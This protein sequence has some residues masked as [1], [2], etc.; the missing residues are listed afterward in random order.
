V[1][2]FAR[3]SAA[4]T[5]LYGLNRRAEQ[6]LEFRPRLRK[7]RYTYEVSVLVDTLQSLTQ[8]DWYKF[9]ARPRLPGP[10]A[11]ALDSIADR[12]IF[13]TGAGGSIGSQLSLRIAR[14]RPR[15]LT[16]LDISEQALYRLRASFESEMP[17]NRV[18][19]LLGSVADSQLLDEAFSFTAP[20][21]II[22]AAAHKHLT[23]VEEHVLAAIANNTLATN[24]LLQLAAKH[25]IAR[26]ILLSTDKAVSPTSVM[27]ATK[28]AAEL[29]TL[30][31]GGIVVRLANVLASEGSVAPIFMRQI[32]AGQP[33]TITDSETRRYFLTGEEAVDVLLT[34]ST[35]APHSATVVP[36]ISKSQSILDL[37]HFL[38]G[39]STIHRPLNI[40]YIG[41]GVGEKQHEALWS[42]D[43][44]AFSESFHGSLRVITNQRPIHRASEMRAKLELLRIAVNSR[45]LPQAVAYL[46]S[47]VPDYTPSDTVRRQVLEYSGADLR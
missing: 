4:S 46:Q 9:L 16:L 25:K 41:L 21:L 30:C 18:S 7:T 14:L 29:D 11:S 27:G 5:E 26:T 45:K 44:E 31:H 2:R 24:T 33:I 15:K 10:T 17:G 8:V 42:L 1:A 32:A 40:R 35:E 37:A 36:A 43:E 22:H 47:I 6:L 34:A 28:H 38:A 39:H 3:H 20:D 12:S 13:I 23:L 19:F